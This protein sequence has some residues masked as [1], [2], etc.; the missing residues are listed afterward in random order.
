M[1]IDLEVW[2]PLGADERIRRALARD[3]RR[4][5]AA[6]RR[7]AARPAGAP[8]KERLG[9][10]SVPTLVVTA[11]HDPAGFREIGPLVRAARRTRATSSST[12]TTT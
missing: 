11:A 3:A 6:G 7:R 8:A 4:E 12:P 1:E 9:E 2:A 10:L 5:P